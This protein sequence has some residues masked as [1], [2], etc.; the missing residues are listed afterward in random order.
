MLFPSESILESRRQLLRDLG[1][2]K[3]GSEQAFRQALALDPDDHVSL[4]FLAQ[5]RAEAGDIA[6]TEKLL[7]RAIQAQPCAWLPYMRLS[8]LLN[9]QEALSK[10]LAELACRKVLLDL[11]SLKEMQKEESPF[12][13]VGQ[14]MK[15]LEGLSG[16]ERFEMLAEGLRDQ[17]DLEPLA[18]TA[19]LRSLRLVHQLQESDELEPEEVDALVQE[20][21]SI[22][23]LLVGVLRGWA[24]NVLAENDTY[25]VANAIA[26]LGEIGDAR[27]IPYLLELVDLEDAELSGP[28]EWA[29][30]R[31]VE[32]Q[33]DQAAQVFAEIAP[34]LD[35]QEKVAVASR[36]L[37]YPQI[38]ATGDLFER[39][40]ANLDRLESEEREDCFQ[41][42]MSTA[43]LVLGRPGLDLSRTMLRLHGR[44]L[45]RKSRRDCDEIIEEFG[46][47][48]IPERPPAE[49]SPWTV[50]DLCG[51]TIDWEAEMEES[52]DD[53]DDLPPEPVRRKSAP[54]RNDPCW[55]GS[56]KKYKKCHLDA[57]EAEERGPAERDAP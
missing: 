57:D 20:G 10:G 32:Q 51:G 56:G 41:I 22:V 44:M 23:P 42:L 14:G 19:R 33:P 15:E 50:Y 46:S 35:G 48:K 38:V 26:L 49:P 39:L 47:I 2:A 21:E 9:D 11:N 3:I 28:C 27:A 40:F 45:S 52:T 31:I 6:E 34:N 17:R 24:Q 55:C 4:M 12:S 25:T 30:D 13:Q 43:I 5:K 29:L 18:V 37:R 36:L 8:V 16:Q 53:D 54:G 7:W 1:K